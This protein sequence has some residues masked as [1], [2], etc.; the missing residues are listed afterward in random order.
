MAPPPP[1]PPLP[2]EP[3]FSAPK[4]DRTTRPEPPSTLI[5]IQKQSPP[6]TLAFV[7]KYAALNLSKKQQTLPQKPD[8]PSSPQNLPIVSVQPLAHHRPDIVHLPNDNS[9]TIISNSQFSKK[10]TTNSLRISQIIN[11]SD[12]NGI[13]TLKLPGNSNRVSSS[14][15]TQNSSQQYPSNRNCSINNQDGKT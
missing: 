1:P 5:P 2:I 7:N 10:M 14:R 15:R 3:S 8:T 12:A 11:D 4:I 9:N 13:V 6:A